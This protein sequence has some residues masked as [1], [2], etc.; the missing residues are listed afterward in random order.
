M[1]LPS[2]KRPRTERK[3]R[4]SHHAL[5]L[6]NSLS[7]VSCGKPVLPHHVCLHCGRYN[8]RQVLAI[9][10]KAE[11]KLKQREKARAKAETASD[12][13]TAEKEKA[14]AA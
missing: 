4:A 5:Q 2:K 9:R 10:S 11:K 3:T 7:C 13:E 6:A 1:G 12:A 8:N 14:Q